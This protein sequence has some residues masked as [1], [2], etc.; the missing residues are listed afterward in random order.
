M[1]DDKRYMIERHLAEVERHVAQGERHLERQRALILELLR[2]GHD[3]TQALKL[4]ATL[5]QSQR[6][7]IEDRDRLQAALVKA[8]ALIG[9]HTD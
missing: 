7:H 2:D 4:L 1:H 8:D 5:E 9:S 6:L 3:A